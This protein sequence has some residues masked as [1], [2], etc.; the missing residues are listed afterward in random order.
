[1]VKGISKQKLKITMTGDVTLMATFDPNPLF[2]VSWIS[3]E[4]IIL[5]RPAETEDYLL[6]CDSSHLERY[7]Y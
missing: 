3:V 5:Y 7:T 4:E 2:M 1:V 6:W